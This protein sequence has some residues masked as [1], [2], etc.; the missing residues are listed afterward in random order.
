MHFDPTGGGFTDGATDGAR[1]RALRVAGWS[2]LT[3]PALYLALIF[4]TV[5]DQAMRGL[6]PAFVLILAAATLLLLR[7]GKARFATRLLVYGTFAGLIPTIVLHGGLQA[8]QT[9]A[10]PLAILLAG[11]LL[12]IRHAAALTA[13]GLAFVRGAGGL[14][15]RPAGPDYAASPV[16]VSHCGRPADHWPAHFIH[17]A[18]QRQPAR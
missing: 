10:L 9:I 16:R 8:P 2:L 17:R 12:G 4:L 1:L 15:G 11:W 13:L 3:G 5:P 14:S 18:Q 7:A 6:G